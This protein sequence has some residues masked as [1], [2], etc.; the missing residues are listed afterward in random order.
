LS[1]GSGADI[2]LLLTVVDWVAPESPF[3]DLVFQ[4]LR[5]RPVGEVP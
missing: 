3:A 4:N 5:R 2:M 1:D